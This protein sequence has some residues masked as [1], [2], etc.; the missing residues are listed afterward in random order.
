MRRLYKFFVI[1][2]GFL[3][4]YDS[5]DFF[6]TYWNVVRWKILI[7]LNWVEPLILW[8]LFAYVLLKYNKTYGRNDDHE[9]K[10]DK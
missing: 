9:D 7:S 6:M 8:C 5:M 3:A 2:V 10:E 1:V 4:W